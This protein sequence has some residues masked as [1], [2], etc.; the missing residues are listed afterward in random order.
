VRLAHQEVGGGAPWHRRGVRGGVELRRAEC[1][2]LLLPVA[3]VLHGQGAADLK[4]LGAGLADGVAYRVE[5]VRLDVQRPGAVVLA[6]LRVALV[7]GELH[8][9]LHHRVAV[10]EGLR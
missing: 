4:A 1:G 10:V 2:P 6:V 9:E 7:G 8:D 3:D 5:H